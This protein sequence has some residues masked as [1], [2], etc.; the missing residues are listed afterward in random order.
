MGLLFIFSPPQSF[1]LLCQC[2]LI[3]KPSLSMSV[4]RGYGNAITALMMTF[5]PLSA[6]QDC[7]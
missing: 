2:F 6:S 7:N 4:Q 5:S 1:L 3:K